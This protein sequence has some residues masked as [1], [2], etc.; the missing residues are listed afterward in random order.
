[1]QLT[2]IELSGFKSFARPTRLE[3]GQGLTVVIGPNGSGKSNLA[4]GIRWVLGEQSTKQLRTK[5]ST[6]VIFSGSDTRARQGK[7]QVKLFFN[8][9]SGRFP[10]EAPEITIARRVDQTGESEYTLNEDP[11]RLIDLQQALAEAGIGAKSY[12]VISQGMVDRYLTATPE[13]RRELFDEATGIRALQIRLQRTR[14]QLTQV[15]QHAHEIT[16]ILQELE[17]R[18]RV[19]ARQVKK[20]AEREEVLQEFAAKQLAYFTA[21]WHDTFGRT[22]QLAAT[23]TSTNDQQQQAQQERQQVEA[24]LLAGFNGPATDPKRPSLRMLLRRCQELLQTWQAGT[25]PTVAAIEELLVDIDRSLKIQAGADAIPQKTMAQQLAQV[26]EAELVTERERSLT[27]MALQQ[28]RQALV[29]LEGKILREA[30]D[31]GLKQIQ[32]TPPSL[33]ASVGKSAPTQNEIERLQMRLATIGE[34]DP[35]IQKEYEE[36]RNRGEHLRTQMADI[37]ATQAKITELAQTLDRDITQQFEQRFDVIQN[38]FSQHFVSLFGGGKAQLAAIPEGI[39]IT[40]APPGKRT[41]HVALLSGGEKALTSLALLF[42]I[43]E[44]QQPPFLV[45]DEVDAALD[46]ANSRRFVEALKAKSLTTQCIVISHNR[47][48][49]AAADVL[50]GVTMGADSVSK[51]YS[52]KLENVAEEVHQEAPN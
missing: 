2:A 4:E 28:A 25:S 34:P 35:L 14:K 24:T 40:V 7:A 44:A 18:L 52:V 19:L 47:E 41:R 10:I 31:T 23:L 42:A 15:N 22:Q 27:H 36:V 33:E 49:F 3:F 16:T 37:V 6:D 17:P 46:E 13:A 45:L 9:E 38:S 26:R 32:T 20:F 48:M 43:L 11:I 12:T 1:M 50:Y 21:S 39:E 29:N 5:A 51:V 8:N 30:G